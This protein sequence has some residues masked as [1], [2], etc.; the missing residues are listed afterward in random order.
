MEESCWAASNS[1]RGRTRDELGP[2]TACVC[3]INAHRNTRKFI[4]LGA[5]G[6][7]DPTDRWMRKIHVTK[8]TKPYKFRW[9]GDIDGP[10]PY[11]FIG[12]GGFYFAHTGISRLNATKKRLVIVV[13][14]RRPGPARPSRAPVL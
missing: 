4:R 8:P 12:S 11:E 5:M 10:K 7:T 9:L 13:G 2:H 6:V 1:S 14:P 3:E